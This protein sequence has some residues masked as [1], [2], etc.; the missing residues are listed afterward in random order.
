MIWVF[1]VKKKYPHGSCHCQLSYKLSAWQPS[2]SAVIQI[3][4]FFF[5]GKYVLLWQIHVFFNTLFVWQ[6]TVAAAIWVICMTTDSDSCHM[7][8]F[9]KEKFYFISHYCKEIPRKLNLVYF[10]LNLFVWLKEAPKHIL[11]SLQT[12]YITSF[13]FIWPC[14]SHL[15]PHICP[16]LSDWCFDG[17]HGQHKPQFFTKSTIIS[18]KTAKKKNLR[19][20][21]IERGLGVV[22]TAFI[23]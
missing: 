15:S 2:L 20:S 11:C 7:D 16:N 14:R 10:T 12:P 18:I 9:L 8:F 3:N 4:V 19:R 21:K 17:C 23:F 22:L 13:K 5:N 6:P 1:S